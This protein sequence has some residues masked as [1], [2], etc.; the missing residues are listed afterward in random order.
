MS[1]IE[2]AAQ[3][4]YPL[5]AASASGKKARSKV[6]QRMREAEEKAL[7]EF[8]LGHLVGTGIGGLPKPKPLPLED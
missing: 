2:D 8:G 7:V 1:R 6:D 3:G 5:I 4:P